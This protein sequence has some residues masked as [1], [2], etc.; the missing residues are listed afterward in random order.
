[1]ASPSLLFERTRQAIESNDVVAFDRWTKHP[2]W[3][4]SEDWDSEWAHAALRSPNCQEWLGRVESLGVRLIAGYRQPLL[5]EATRANNPAA[6]EWLLE[7]GADVDMVSDF[8]L[9]TTAGHYALTARAT[10]AMELLWKKTGRVWS[11]LDSSKFSVWVRP[12]S[13]AMLEHMAKRGWSPDHLEVCRFYPEGQSFRQRLADH[14]EPVPPAL[15]AWLESVRLDG[16]LQR[17]EAGSSSG[18]AVRPRSRL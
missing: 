18:Q 6:M 2:R 10:E 12:E 5:C 8:G 1:M 4:R 11:L 3:R 16:A 15:C 13:L 17:P 7:K 14:H 9:G